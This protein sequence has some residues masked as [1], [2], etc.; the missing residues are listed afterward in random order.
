MVVNVEFLLWILL[1]QACSKLNVLGNFKCLFALVIWTLHTQQVR[2]TDAV[3]CVQAS[4]RFQKLHGN[5]DRMMSPYVYSLS[6]GRKYRSMRA[7]RI[8]A[9]IRRRPSPLSPLRSLRRSAMLPLALVPVSGTSVWAARPQ[10]DT[11][12]PPLKPVS[13]QPRSQSWILLPDSGCLSLDA[14]PF[15]Q[16]PFVTGIQWVAEDGFVDHEGFSGLIIF[17]KPVLRLLVLRY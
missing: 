9:R 15:I 14:S 5:N 8:R 3:S 17:L 1:Q 11:D 10:Y 6:Y 4:A 13:P 7:P 2:H 12:P 16:E